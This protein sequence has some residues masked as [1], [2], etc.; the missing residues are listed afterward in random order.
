MMMTIEFLKGKEGQAYPQSTHLS[1]FDPE[2]LRRHSADAHYLVTQGGETLARASLWW[3]DVPALKGERL[4]V[5]GHF[6]A[7]TEAAATALISQCLT[8]LRRQYC[9]LAVGPMDG[10]TWRSYR[11]VTEPGKTPPFFLEPDNPPDY[12]GFFMAAGFTPI[13]EYSSA[14]VTEL[15]KEDERIP[16]AKARLKDAGIAWRALDMVRFEKELRAIYRLSVESFTQNFLYT[17][18]EEEAFLAQYQAIAPHVRPELTLMAEQDGDL[19][20]YLFGIP[21]LN[22]ARRGEEVDTFIVKTVAVAPTRKVAGLGSVL[23]AESHRIAYE[24]GYRGAIHALMHDAN[25][26][27][28]ISAHYAHTMRRYTLYHQ[29]IES[30]R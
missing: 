28:N 21:D 10:N 14:R 18:I 1:P 26:S 20:G 2:L 17:P 9:T 13:A 5:I 25:K 24:L 29:R 19:L 27:R 15:T 4:G 7:Y 16:R 11:F 8:R 3:Q 22:Q 12:P 30:V 23:V 6:A